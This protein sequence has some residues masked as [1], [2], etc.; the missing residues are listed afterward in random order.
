MKVAN[1]SC[2]TLF[3]LARALGGWALS[4]FLKPIDWVLGL[5]RHL[6]SYTQHQA[7]PTVSYLA[8]SAIDSHF[9]DG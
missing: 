5:C 8:S 4:N 3:F 7:A 9:R 6:A 2:L 1:E